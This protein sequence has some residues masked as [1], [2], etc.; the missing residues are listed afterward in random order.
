MK[1]RFSAAAW[2]AAFVSLAG[3]QAPP[4]IPDFEAASV[5][6]SNAVAGAEFTAAGIPLGAGRL[7]EGIS[8]HLGFV[9]GPGSG[10]PGRITYTGV[11]LRNLLARAY[12]LKPSQISGPGWLDSEHYDVLATLPPGT[13]AAKLALMLQKL[14]TDRFKMAS[15]RE[16]KQLP[17]Y[18]LT[19]AQGGPK[20]QPGAPVTDGEAARSQANVSAITAMQERGLM[21]PF[22][23]IRRN[24][25]TIAAFAEALSNN[26]GRPVRDM[27][28]LGG[29]YD[30]LL[31]WI[32]EGAQIPPPPA[33]DDA[34]N[35]DPSD[36]SLFVAIREQLGL[37]LESARG[38]VETV[39][40]DK[41]ER[42]PTEN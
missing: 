36:L 1:R 28:N 34:I 39:V 6:R 42:T 11:T 15:H 25:I 18:N 13:D 27:T 40:V 12:G 9:G 17:V 38:P 35:A 32:P 19:V 20:L 5:K 29:R 16:T 8:T 33:G 4:N 3:A 37:K 21:G 24:D 7:P 10:D 31:T 22:R 14:L 23:I 2:T 26:V 30:F 41:A